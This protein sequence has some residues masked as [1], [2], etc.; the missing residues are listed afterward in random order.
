MGSRETISA[1]P[2]RTASAEMIWYNQLGVHTLNERNTNNHKEICARA[3]HGE[4][5]RHNWQVYVLGHKKCHD[6]KT[7]LV[8]K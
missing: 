7:A 1:Q 4:K 2:G 6:V 3:Y 5:K 8:E